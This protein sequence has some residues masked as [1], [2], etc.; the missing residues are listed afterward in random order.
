MK[1]QCSIA[2]PPGRAGV[3]HAPQLPRNAA[4]RPIPGD[5]AQILGKVEVVGVLRRV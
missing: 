3:A 4:Y 5:Q 2:A 1:P